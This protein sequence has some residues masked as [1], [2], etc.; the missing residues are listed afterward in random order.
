MSRSSIETV[1]VR[2]T[3]WA[4]LNRDPLEDRVE[5]TCPQ[6]GTRG[7]KAAPPSALGLSLYGWVCAGPSR[8]DEHVPHLQAVV[9]ALPVVLVHDRDEQRRFDAIFL[10]DREVSK[11]LSAEI[12][13]GASQAACSFGAIVVSASK[14]T[15]ES[16]T[17]V[18]GQV[19]FLH[20]SPYM[21]ERVIHCIGELQHL[22][23][24]LLPCRCGPCGAS[25]PP[26]SNI[27]GR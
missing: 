15:L 6:C 20:L 11:E 5:Y 14:P 16:L 4:A 23:F 12:S 24:L 3:G 8:R 26:C 13:E 17:H 18:K 2:L 27:F 9:A 19:I 25:S 10:A 7:A 1:G 22:E 21:I